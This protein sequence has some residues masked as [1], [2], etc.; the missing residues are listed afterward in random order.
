MKHKYFYILSALIIALA[1]FLRLYKIENRA[2]FDWDQNRDYAAISEIAKGNFTLIG[3]VAKGEGGFFL[4]PL[5]YYLVTPVFLLLNGSPIA[6]P[7]TSA[8]LDV[9]A[10]A[11][12][13]LLLRKYFGD[14]PTLLLA[15]FWAI[16]WFGIEASRVSWNVAL[17]QVWVVLFI[18]LSLAQLTAI[19]SLLFGLILGLSW[20]IHASLIPLSLLVALF[21]YKPTRYHL[22]NLLLI[23]VGYLFALSPLILFDLR[24]SGLE[25]HLIAQFLSASGS[26]SVPFSKVFES[27]FARFGKNSIAILTAA[28]D[29]HFWWGI[30][31]GLL[32]L[33]GLT[34]KHP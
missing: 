31:F 2:P 7:Y 3:P 10:I 15:F 16:S 24:H 22:K 27:V 14:R 6:Q 20:H 5:Y 17:L 21:T 4:G 18:Y 25:R 29:L 12:V 33:L 1:L 8:F 9:M 32:T 23:S 28:S 34:N 30:F 19:T 26:I 11:L 13:V